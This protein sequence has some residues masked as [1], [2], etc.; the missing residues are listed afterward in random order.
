MLYVFDVPE[1]VPPSLPG[2]GI[3][4]DLAHAPDVFTKSTRIQTQSACL[5][6]ADVQDSSGGDLLQCLAHPPIP[7][8]WPMTGCPTVN[9][10]EGA[11]F[12]SPSEDEWYAR[13]L[14]LPVVHQLSQEEPHWRMSHP[15]P[16]SLYI[17]HVQSLMYAV[18]FNPLQP[19]LLYPWLVF[20]AL[21]RD[22]PPA[23]Y[24]KAAVFLRTIAILLEAPIF[25]LQPEPDG[26]SW[27]QE[28]LATSLPSVVSVIDLVSGE[29]DVVPRII[30]DVLIELSPL[31][32]V[33]WTDL[34]KEGAELLVP[35]GVHLIREA[36]FV[37]R[38]QVF[39]QNAPKEQVST[40]FEKAVA[41]RFDWSS[42]S[43]QIEESND[44]RDISTNPVAAKSLFVALAVLRDLSS[45]LKPRAS[46]SSASKTHHDASTSSGS[47]GITGK[48]AVLKKAPEIR[49]GWRYFVL[50]DPETNEPYAGEKETLERLGLPPDTPFHALTTDD[51]RRL[52]KKQAAE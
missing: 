14:F 25:A 43:F 11:L 41:I 52:R 38:L 28:F 1:W 46:L 22:P 30:T 44:W 31:E 42:R 40:L 47:I 29:L 39:F 50:R 35:R 5:I 36:E 10:S 51:F 7:V 23:A 3:L 9:L 27:N 19:P 13:L 8:Q 17:E 33:G 16:L 20:P 45:D 15:V 2:H 4:V 6:A 12:P 37:W 32:C 24:E 34:V 18:Q 21:L 26:K 49:S 48:L